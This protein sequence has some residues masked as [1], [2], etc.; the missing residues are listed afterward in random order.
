MFGRKIFT[1]SDAIRR[2]NIENMSWRP[3]LIFGGGL[4][5]IDVGGVIGLHVG[6]NQRMNKY[7]NSA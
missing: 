3:K 4:K 5:C 2:F 6:V 7:I 1:M